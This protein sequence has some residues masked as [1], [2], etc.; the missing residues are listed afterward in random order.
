[1]QRRHFLTAAGAA[2]LSMFAPAAARAAEFK[3]VIK[4]A[5]IIRKPEEAELRDL[6]A[7]GFDGVEVSHI[8]EDETEAKRTRDLIEGIGLK[9]HSVL[10]G[11]AE[12]NSED[13]AKVAASYAVTEQ[14]LRTANWLGA[15]T[16][17]LVPCRVG[18]VEGV[19]M[20]RPWE[21][22]IAFDQ[23][24]GH[25]SRVVQGD[26]APYAKYI[27]LQN[28][29][30]DTS[31]EQV[32]KLIPLAEKLNVII[33]L[34]N[35]WNNLWVQPDL[36]QNFVASF[37]HPYAQAYYDVG[38]HV[39]Y[40]RPVHDWIHTLGGL[41]KKIH[42]KDYALAPDQHSGKFVHPRDGSIDWPK[43]RQ[44]LEDVGYN[45]WITVEDN[46]LPLPEFAQ[47]LDQIIAGV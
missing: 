7:A 32:R 30:T 27:E 1:M 13:P 45:G 19:T 44:A 39:K 42:I 16:I 36:Y 5:K 40:L 2:S 14:A 41:I 11:W 15:E 6:K 12:F 17:L 37:N 46:G 35:V 9:V 24:T 21:F 34:E 29:S 10:R 28:R 33:G 38:N 20:P 22:D 43:M 4:K 26:N 8:F 25:V 3:T 23:T 31:K 47:R 18:G